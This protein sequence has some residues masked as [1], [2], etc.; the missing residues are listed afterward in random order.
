[1]KKKLPPIVFFGNEKLA[2]GVASSS[3]IVDSLRNAGW[4]IEQVVTGPPSELKQHEAK[5]AVLAAYGHIVPQSVL[6]A[7]PLG[8]V[9][10]HPSLLPLYRGS[11][12]IEQALLDGVEKTGVSIMRLDRAMDEGPLY[13]Q[14]SLKINAYETKQSLTNRLHQLGA[15]LL[16]STLPLIATSAHKARKQPHPNRATYTKRIQKIDG[17]IN[18]DLPA[19][20]IEKQIRA[21][22]GWPRSRATLENIDVII[23]QAEVIDASGIPGKLRGGDGLI[24]HCGKASLR[25]RR[26]IPA[27]KKEM[28]DQEFLRGYKARLKLSSAG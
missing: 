22:A 3:I 13:K 9:N 2:T 24:V 7:F 1:M 20:V 27:G 15:D 14:Q 17:R 25:I 23:T 19:E 26:I 12:P 16:I 28:T 8:I 21:Y 4:E 6:D 11:T 5:L 18:W 10:V